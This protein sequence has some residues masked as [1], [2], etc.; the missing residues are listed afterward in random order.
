[1]KPKVKCPTC[2]QLVSLTVYGNYRAHS[3]DQA[4]CPSSSAVAPWAPAPPAPAHEP[5]YA[6][7]AHAAAR[8]GLDVHETAETLGIP[9]ARAATLLDQAR[10]RTTSMTGS[11]A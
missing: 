11:P 6:L 3:Y 10:R 4:R 5:D 7:A 9:L 2:E 1:M 8:L